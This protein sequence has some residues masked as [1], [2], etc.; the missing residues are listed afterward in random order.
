[1]DL[2]AFPYRDPAPAG[3]GPLRVL[4]VGTLS[5]WQGI[6]VLLDAVQLAGNERAI[7]LGLAGPANRERLAELHSHIRRAGLE[8]RVTI[9]PPVPR[10]QVAGLFHDSHVTAVPLTAADRNTVQGC[11][12]LKLL[13]AMAAGCPVVAS[14][15]PVVREL[16]DPGAHF[17]PVPPGDVAALSGAIVQAGS[18]HEATAARARAARRHVEQ[19]FTW[20]NST[21]RLIALYE[22]LLGSPASS[23]ARPA[24]SAAGE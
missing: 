3:H 22:E 10:A 18:D 16:A 2:A 20:Q 7:H 6:E 1:M 19:H 21:N 4:Y 13:E 9:L 11:C 5:R 23:A 24:C 14:D 8:S 17:L 15:L 12:P